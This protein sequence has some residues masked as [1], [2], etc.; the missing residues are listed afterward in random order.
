MSKDEKWSIPHEFLDNNLESFIQ[1][2]KQPKDKKEM[3]PKIR[4]PYGKFKGK[5]MHEI[6]LSYLKYAAENFGEFIACAADE[7]WRWRDNTQQHWEE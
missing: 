1:L 6:P 5:E 7:E 3:E 4:M 2:I